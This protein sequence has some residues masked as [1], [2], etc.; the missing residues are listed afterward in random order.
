MA[1]SQIFIC[2]HGETEWSL[3]GK[4][5]GRTDLAITE[6]G[7]QQA[8]NLKARLSALSVDFALTSPL[9][10]ARTTCELAGFSNARTEPLMVEWDYGDYEGLTHA[11]IRKLNPTWRLTKDGAPNGESPE[12][13]TQRV[14]QFLFWLM[15]QH[16]NC[17]L[18][19]HGH[20]LKSLAARWLKLEI[21][22]ASCF[23]LTVASLS[24]LSFERENPVI[25]LW[26][27]A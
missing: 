17:L 16:G 9:L 12:Q 18:F 8:K 19:S 24:T 2:R 5:T 1:I 21:A 7:R 20:F 13:M 25:S 6:R 23:A 11:E 26:N 14:D 22:Q 4:H 3:S 27:S 15:Q 10:R